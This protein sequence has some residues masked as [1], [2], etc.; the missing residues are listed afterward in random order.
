MILETTSNATRQEFV[1]EYILHYKN[2][3]IKTKDISDGYHTF[4]DLYHHRAILFSVV[5]NLLKDKAWKSKLH[6]D[7]KMFDN[8][9][10]IVGIETPEG[11]YSYHYKMEY[12][13]MFDVKELDYAPEWDGHK[14]E[15]ITRLLSLLKEGD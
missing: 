9:M 14:P 5:C 7:G 11:H 4:G 8:T 1:Q 13:D 10:F 6:S 12:W 3:Q 2:T 15:D